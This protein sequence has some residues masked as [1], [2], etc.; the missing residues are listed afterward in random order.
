M[1]SVKDGCTALI[2]G[3]K[4]ELM[5]ARDLARRVS[6]ASCEIKDA[7]KLSEQHIR[8]S[9]ALIATPVVAMSQRP[10]DAPLTAREMQVLKL[11]AKGESSKKIGH[12][13]GIS[14]KTVEF[15]RSNAVRK[16]R[17]GNRADIV[18]YALVRGWLQVSLPE[19][20]S[21]PAGRRKT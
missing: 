6:T 3:L 9:R 19:A 17:L 12:E 21:S 16:L 7:M 4:S 14:I 10:A 15:H 20:T 11:V 5:L 18:R 8:S 1:P 13:L 2:N